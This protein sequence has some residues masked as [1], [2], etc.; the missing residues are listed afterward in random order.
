MT[1]IPKQTKTEVGRKNLPLQKMGRFPQ[2]LEA[3]IIEI[4]TQQNG[5]F[6][7]SPRYRDYP[8]QRACQRMKKRGVLKQIKY[9]VVEIY[10][11]S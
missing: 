4:A 6:S 1:K 10:K 5:Q 3:R 9:G 2:A 11:L 7:V 8:I